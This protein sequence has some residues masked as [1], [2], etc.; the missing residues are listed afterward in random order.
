MRLRSFATVASWVLTASAHAVD[1]G[2]V[3]FDW[4]SIEYVY[5]FG[6]SYTFVQGTRGHANFS[7]IGDLL[8][9]SFTPYALLTDEIIYKNTSSDGANWIEYLTGCFAGNPAVC[10]R[11]LW[12]FAFAGADI[13]GN[14]LPLHHNFTV[15]LVD[16]VKQWATYATDVIPRPVKNTLTAWWIGINDTGDTVSN[17][18]ITD[19]TAFW[20][21]EM[22]SYFNAVQTAYDHGL[23][24][25]HL[26]INVPPEERAPGHVNNTNHDTIKAH[27]ELYNSILEDYVTA[28][29]ERNPRASVLTF[30][31]HSWFNEVLDNAAAYGFSNITGYC[32]CTD[33]SY[34]WYNTGHPTE[35]VHR[36]LAS[37]IEESLVNASHS[38]R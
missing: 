2:N 36:L 19:W 5:A 25:A 35:H 26:F 6:D 9:L 31:A 30:D 33:P 23:Q 38:S 37:A 15:P 24:G 3:G 28:F 1:A 4:R 18:S 22:T 8:D 29:A 16:Q 11:K 32:T 17:A 7:F 20:N 12:N 13:D 34:F 10:P 21:T 14:I 27:I